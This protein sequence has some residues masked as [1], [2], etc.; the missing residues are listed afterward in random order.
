MPSITTQ[1]Q[2][3]I[4]DIPVGQTF[5]ARDI[6]DTIGANAGSVGQILNRGAIG[7][8]FL[9]IDKASRDIRVYRRVSLCPTL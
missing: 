7:S 8:E 1:V 9:T 4:R 5:T 2:M 6:A 3:A